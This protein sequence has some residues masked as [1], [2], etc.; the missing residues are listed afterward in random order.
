MIVPMSPAVSGSYRKPLK[1][2]IS[3]IIVIVFTLFVMGYLLFPQD[4]KSRANARLV[5]LP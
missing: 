5:Y 4:K 1:G 3:G 2:R